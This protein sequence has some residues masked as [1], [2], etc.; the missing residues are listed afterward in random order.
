MRFLCGLLVLLALCAIA[1]NSAA[2]LPKD[3]LLA[4]SSPQDYSVSVDHSDAHSGA[5][6]ALLASKS[7]APKGFGTLMQMVQAG[8]FQGKRLRFTAYVRSKGVK[9]WAGLWLRVDGSGASQLGFDNMHDRPIKG[10]SNWKPYSIVLDVPEEAVAIAFGI[11][12]TGPGEVW[13][14]TGSLETVDQSVP[15]TGT[16]APRLPEVPSNLDF[17]K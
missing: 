11:L 3:W 17:E 1:Q 4:G 2:E 13:I 15:T 9:E 6:S 12:L 7:D 16:P 10:D 14:D 5:A 8:S